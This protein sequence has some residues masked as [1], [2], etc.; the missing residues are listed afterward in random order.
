MRKIYLFLSSMFVAGAASAQISLTNLAPAYSQD[1]DGMAATLNLPANWRMGVS[2]SSPTWAAGASVVTQQF[3]SGTPTSGGTYNFGSTAA[4]RA[5]GAMTSGSFASPNNPMAFFVNDGTT[6]ITELIISYDA[7]RYRVNSAAA[8]IQFFYSTNGTSWT[9]VTAGDIAT[10][11]FPTGTN[12]Y[13]FAS[14]LTVSRPGITISSLSITPGS[15]FYLRWLINTTGSNSQGI[16]IDNVSVTATYAATAS[17]LSTIVAGPVAAPASIS[18]LVNNSGAASTNFS[19]SVV[20]DGSTN[21]ADPTLISQIIIGQGTSNDAALANWTQAIAGAELSDGTNTAAGTVT[22]TGI[23][24][25]SLPT[26]TGAIGYVA[27]NATKNYTV[28][29]WLNTALGGTLPTTIDGKQFEFLVQTSSVSTA[30]SGSSGIAA[31][32]SV[33][34]GAGTNVVAVAATQLSFIQNTTSPTGLNTAMAPA[35]TVS[36]NDANGNRDLDFTGNLRVTSTGTLSGTPVVTAAVAGLTT[37][38]SLTHTATGT[39]ITLNIERDGTLDWDITSAA[40]DIQ[41]ASAPTDY[42]RS[43]ASGN[44]N[45][46][47]TWESSA[48]GVSWTAATIAPT[49]AANTIT[50]RNGHTVTVTTSAT[51]DQIEIA[52]GGVLE[53]ASTT[54]NR[55]TIADGTG[56]DLIIQG[57]GVYHVTSGLGYT[58]YQTINPGATVSIETNGIIR[59]GTGGSIGGGGHNAFLTTATSYLWNNGAIFDWNTTSA[60]GATGVTFFPDAMAATPILRISAT[61]I[62]LGGGTALTVNGVL[63]ANA[64]ISFTGNSDKIFRNGITGTGN[65]TMAT[66]TGALV[67][68]GTAATLGGT[69][70]INPNANG[71]RIGVITT[72]TLQSSKTINGDINLQG[73]GFIVLGNNNLVVAGDINNYSPSGYI[74]TNGTGVL[75]LNTVAGTLRPF[76]VGNST[77][78]PVNIVNGSSLNWSVRVED[79]VNNVVAPFNTSKAVNRT[80]HIVPSATVSTAPDIT[81]YFNDAENSQLVDDAAYNGDP[82]RTVRVWHYNGS[83]W[84]AAGGIESLSPAN[85]VQGVALTGQLSFSPFA[86]SKTTAPLPVNFG[87]VKAVQQSTGIRIDWSNLTER[88]VL[89]YSVERSADG[90]SFTAIGDVNARLNNGE[91]AEYSFFDATPVRGVNYYRIKSAENDGRS[92]FSIVV[93]VDISDGQTTVVVLYPNPIVKG[94]QLSLQATSLAKGTYTIRVVNMQG[95][96]IVNQVFVHQGGAITEAVQMPANTQAGTYQLIISGAEQQMVRPFVIQ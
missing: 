41:I 78:N 60:P 1:F 63:E 50:I 37:F 35:V 55:L 4:E 88:N 82:V 39:G 19:F 34:S 89:N 65:V 61:L 80:W 77:L 52:N 81:L 57:G 70:T 56:D 67:I 24:F 94:Q 47:A 6:N 32:Q 46:A 83:D 59:L 43:A 22:A 27:D 26:T 96:Q 15:N 38:A 7:E 72:V 73:S 79:A 51:A 12:S 40:F 87:N 66:G 13:T 45:S 44:W 95:Q 8:S 71:L 28:K 25:A 75:Q 18:S 23:T 48:D 16:A 2:T 86:I 68:D 14:P 64:N 11:S 93:K 10:S 92:K 54:G 17:G 76:P 85:G 58:N 42:F 9:A 5:V 29:V 62:N 30:G 20:D 31:S 74:R 53:N 33:N 90:R 84:V 49:A 91:K 69:G 3:S 21:D 36:A